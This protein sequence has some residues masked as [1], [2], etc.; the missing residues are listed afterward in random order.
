MSNTSRLVFIVIIVV[1]IIAGTYFAFGSEGGFSV[2]G[3]FAAKKCVPS[4]GKNFYN[5]CTVWKNDGYKS[6]PSALKVMTT[7][8]ARQMCDKLLNQYKEC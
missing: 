4:D 5:A 7:T 1:I 6:K 2:T 3:A 8:S